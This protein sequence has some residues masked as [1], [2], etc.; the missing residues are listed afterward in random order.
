MQK[1]S[2]LSW[3]ISKGFEQLFP[4]LIPSQHLTSQSSSFINQHPII[5]TPLLAM[6]DNKA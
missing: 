3:D 1:K 2:T 6:G 5:H 4:F